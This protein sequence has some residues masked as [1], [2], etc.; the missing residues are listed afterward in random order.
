MFALLKVLLQ[1]LVRLM[2]EFRQ[3]RKNSLAQ[4]EVNGQVIYL[5]RALN[6]AFCFDEQLIYVTDGTDSVY[7]TSL[8][9]PDEDITIA[10]Y[11]ADADNVTYLNV[12]NGGSYE[13]DYIVNVPSFLNTESDMRTIR[14]IIDYNKPA[15]RS[16]N[17]K[18]Y[19]YE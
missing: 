5:E 16:Y 18:I 15:G 4:M 8:L 1:P 14:E 7:E 10:V 2:E 9:Y 17:I 13:A 6:K 11:P 12:D 19:N 3:Y